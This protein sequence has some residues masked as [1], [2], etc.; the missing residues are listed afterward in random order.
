MVK[1]S[2]FQ[3]K[4]VINVSDGR[5]LGNIGDIDINLMNGKIEAIIIS[6]PGK[7]LGFFGKEDEVVIP[8]KNIVKVGEDVVLVRIQQVIQ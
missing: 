1:I 6:G 2:D 8:W 4:D 3:T 5:K 7:V